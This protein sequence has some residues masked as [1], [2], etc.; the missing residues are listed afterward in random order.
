M[1]QDVEV[2]A[3]PVGDSTERLHCR[4]LV[5]Y[6]AAIGGLLYPRQTELLKAYN[7]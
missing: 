7:H 1:G 4:G 6:V 3:E 2:A 5:A